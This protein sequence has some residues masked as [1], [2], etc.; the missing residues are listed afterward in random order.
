MHYPIV[1]PFIGGICNPRLSSSAIH[2]SRYDF[3]SFLQSSRSILVIEDESSR[4]EDEIYGAIRPMLAVSNGRLILM[5][6]PHGKRGHFFEA[7]E[8][9]GDGWQ[10][11]RITA[12]QCPR[13]SNE[14][15]QEEK[16]A[17]GEWLYRQEYFGEFVETVNQLIHYDDVQ[18]AISTDVKIL[19]T[20]VKI[21]W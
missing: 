19:N 6:T 18:K 4:V 14:F 11:I 21:P 20:G 2:S 16:R 3:N 9:G 12:D 15:L 5:S 8:N 17:L 10:R 13:I 7:Y 1:W